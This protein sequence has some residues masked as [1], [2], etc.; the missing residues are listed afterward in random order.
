MQQQKNR[1]TASLTLIKLLQKSHH[2][3]LLD[4]QKCK[5]VAQMVRHTRTPPPPALCLT[6]SI[7]WPSLI[8]PLVPGALE[9]KEDIIVVVAAAV[10]LGLG[11][12][13]QCGSRRW[14][15]GG[16]GHRQGLR[17]CRPCVKLRRFSR[18]LRVFRTH[19]SPPRRARLRWHNSHVVEDKALGPLLFYPRE[20]KICSRRTPVQ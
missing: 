7:I 11:G 19:G 16:Q 8:S 1:S 6:A 9:L 12:G 20:C 4:L 2:G 5:A 18:F 10:C 15:V 17:S 3:L 13:E 14:L